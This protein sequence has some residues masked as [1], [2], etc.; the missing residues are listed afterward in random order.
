MV[1]YWHPTIKCPFWATLVCM[2]CRNKPAQGFPLSLYR[3]PFAYGSVCSLSRASPLSVWGK[4]PSS[5]LF[6]SPSPSSSVSCLCLLFPPYLWGKWVSF[7]LKPW[8]WWV[9]CPLWSFHLS[10]WGTEHSA[11]GQPFFH[12]AA[13]SVA[14]VYGVN[15]TGLRACPCARASAGCFQSPP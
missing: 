14:S 6:L 12:S 9:L 5:S 4:Y 15:W 2:P 1:Q 13:L 10:L 3:L 8:S 7:V 11:A